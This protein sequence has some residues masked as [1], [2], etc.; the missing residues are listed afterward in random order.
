MWSKARFRSQ[1]LRRVRHE[2]LAKT[3]IST[4]ISSL[5]GLPWE[6]LL[7]LVYFVVMFLYYPYRNVFE[8]DTDEGINLIKALLVG[9]GYPLYLAIWSDQP[10]LFT[11]LLAWAHSLFGYDVNV[12]RTMV[13]VFSSLLV[14]GLGIYLRRV[15]GSW[16]ALAA[17]VLVVLLPFFPQLST[18]I[19]IGLPAISL[20][21][22]A[23]AAI[24]LWHERRNPLWL[25]CSA[26]ACSLS[27]FIKL[28]TGILAPI[29]IAGLLLE[30][31]AAYRRQPHTWKPWLP[32]LIWGAVFGAVILGLLL[33]LVGAGNLQQLIAPHLTT[34]NLQPSE[35]RISSITIDSYLIASW[36]GLLLALV[37][38]LMAI[39]QR[40]WLA[41]YPL[42]WVVAGYLL[43]RWNNPVWFHH[44]LLVTVPAVMLAAGAAGEVLR[45]PLDFFR[46]RR[47]SW[48]ASTLWLAALILV[49]I[50]LFQRLPLV[51]PEFTRTPYFNPKS[52][53]DPPRELR[54]V[55]EINRHAQE[56]E[57]MVT[58]LPI[59]AFRANLPVPPELA[60]FSIK[61]MA[62]G[63]L[64]DAY[65]LE[66]IDRYNPNLILWGRFKL[67]ELREEL[68]SRY[69]QVYVFRGK[70]LYLRRDG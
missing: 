25:V 52:Q 55:R 64:S 3:T 22:L 8:G 24:V 40:R 53:E 49:G 6:H 39:W 1:I 33:L 41:F 69:R 59:Y 37:G 38:V 51:V 61:R 15:W 23:M 30:G 11:H 35:G 46:R 27:M 60:V 10:P 42:A 67:P 14:W 20:A 32:V 44:Q 12:G 36:P 17:V 45:L 56:T 2:S 68:A 9:R 66:I 57:W 29:L 26:L 63:G 48:A 19:M 47:S 16:H 31:Y 50:T 54:I 28:F 4:T 43:L 58:D 65:I 70:V 7:P 62:A 34:R 21:V 5:A 18:L 13:L